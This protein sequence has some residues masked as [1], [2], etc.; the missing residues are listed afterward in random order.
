MKF[1]W[2]SFKKA[3]VPKSIGRLLSVDLPLLGIENVVTKVDTGAF[4]GALH[5]TRIREVIAKDGSKR[6]RFSPLG[7]SRHTLEVASYHK[8]RVKSSNGIISN[9]YAIDT[10]ITIMGQTYPITI[11]LADRRTMKYPML[12]GWNFLRIHGFLVDVSMN[13][14]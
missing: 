7:S 8:R 11:T 13:N 3:D 12:V 1:T 10:D 2:Q 9:R 4:S 14:Q 6:L 5:A